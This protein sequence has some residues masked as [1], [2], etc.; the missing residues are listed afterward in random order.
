M[1]NT[2][3]SAPSPSGL[4]KSAVY[5][6]AEAVAEQL[7]YEPGTD[8]EPVVEGLGGKIRY[9]NLW[10]LKSSASGS[11][12]IR[13]END[14]T[15]FL[16]S[17]TG[18]LRD[19]FTIAHELGHYVLHYVYPNQ[20]G[21]PVGPISAQRHGSGQVEWEANWFAAGFL[22][23]AKA[24]IAAY[25]AADGDLATT[26]AALSVSYTAAEIRAKSLGLEV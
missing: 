24:F 1:P 15:I 19:R 4:S 7:R 25:E 20:M 26:A 18:P 22:M 13:N 21:T 2:S 6:L 11:I 23:P 10:E 3:Y 12:Q 8:L 9:Q 17:H 5:S 16:A 14:F